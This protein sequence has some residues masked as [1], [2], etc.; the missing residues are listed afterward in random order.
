MDNLSSCNNP[1]DEEEDIF[2][3]LDKTF[4]D[5]CY[6]MDLLMASLEKWFGPFGEVSFSNSKFGSDK[7][8][9]Y[10]K[11]PKKEMKK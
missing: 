2:V 5:I 10:N 11:E 7:K 1:W 9:G 6:N 4:L 3:K 8:L